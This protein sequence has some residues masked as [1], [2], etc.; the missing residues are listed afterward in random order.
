MYFHAS[1][2]FELSIAFQ[3]GGGKCTFKLARKVLVS[4]LVLKGVLWKKKFCIFISYKMMKLKW[5][6]PRNVFRE[7]ASQ[8]QV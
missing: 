4:F 5:V 1:E 6:D 8:H 3:G 7:M 2:I